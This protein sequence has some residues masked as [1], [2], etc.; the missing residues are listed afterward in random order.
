MV[1][2]IRDFHLE[3]DHV[4]MLG[5]DYA[6]TV[7][8]QNISLSKEDYKTLADAFL[9]RKQTKKTTKPAAPS[10]DL[11]ELFHKLNGLVGGG[12]AVFTRTRERMLKLL[13]TDE[14]LTP[15][16]LIAAATNIGKDDFLQGNHEDNSKRY[17]N[18]DYLL[19]PKEAARWAED[20]PEKKRSM[21]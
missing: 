20:Q 11:E 3:T 2:K 15:E 18:I 16:D 9:P 10:G 21:F 19:R 6:C 4:V 5:S 17:G 7:D 1:I 12:R 14:R 13:I 8:G